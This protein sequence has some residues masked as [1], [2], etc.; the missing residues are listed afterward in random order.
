M[1][2]GPSSDKVEYFSSAVTAGA[3]LPFPEAARVG[4]LIYLSGMIGIKPGTMELVPG[5]IDAESRQALENIR[6]M[7]AAAGATPGD[8]FKCTIMLADISQWSRFNQIYLEFF[9]E[10]R[11]ARSAFGA[12]GL[13][14]GA[15]VEIECIAAVPGGA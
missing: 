2:T 1:Q 11:P 12:S 15:A 13:A 9:G 5:G 7:L 6:T 8:V 10:H 14:M 3:G 4:P